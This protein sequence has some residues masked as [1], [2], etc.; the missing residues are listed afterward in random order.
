LSRGIN[1][2]GHE[3]G[4]ILSAFLSNFYT[5]T[6]Y[7]KQLMNDL[8]FSQAEQRNM[9]AADATNTISVHLWAMSHAHI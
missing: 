2:D 5:H 1:D 6:K 8:E 3:N 7:G 4:T 9:I